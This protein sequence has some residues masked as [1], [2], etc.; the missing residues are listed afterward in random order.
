MKEGFPAN[1]LIPHYRIVNKLGEGGMGEVYLAQDTKLE[2]RVALKVLP[3]EVAAD[4]ERLKRFGQEARAAS[5]LNHPN[6]L[7]IYEIGEFE[8]ANYIST[9]FVD[10]DTLRDLLHS[11]TISLEK[12][13]DIA[14]QAASAL[15]AAHEAGII[16]RDI[17]PENIMIRHDGLVKV[18][19]FGL[20]KL[21]E[22]PGSDIDSEGETR[23]QVKTAPGVIMGTVQYMSPEQTRAKRT[24]ARS[25]IWSLGCV[26]YEMAAGRPPF[27]GETT[28]DLI[29]EIVKID[30][31]PLVRVVPEAPERLDE[32]VSKALEKS[33]D[34]RYQTV[35]DLLIDLRRLKKKL[36]AE[37]DLDRSHSPHITT[38]GDA[39]SEGRRTEILQASTHITAE[40]NSTSSGAQYLTSGIKQHKFGSAA[41]AVLILLVLGGF[42]YG[43]Y[44]F[45]EKPAPATPVKTVDSIKVQRLTGDGRSRDPRISPDGKFLAYHKLE[46]AERSLWIKQI[47][48][49]SNIPVIKPGELDQFGPPTFSPDGNF[50]Y[51]NAASKSE[52]APAVY[53]VPTLGGTPTKVLTN[54]MSVRFSP[55]GR[56]ISF[57]RFDPATNETAIY[58]ANS[59]GTNERKRRQ[60]Q[61]NNFSGRWR[62]GHPTGNRWQPQPAMIRKTPNRWP[63]SS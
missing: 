33:P 1:S 44:K 49:N 15:A 8:A 24:D 55:D 58:V 61:A 34:E 40:A 25:D 4:G 13:L 53:R 57:G 20:A 35:K 56:E 29:A 36:D 18:L 14:I 50:V 31:E 23:A 45:L 6:I 19:D 32:I 21:S 22:S 46:G 54:A 43:I 11:K 3:D 16:H 5:A 26:I 48:T 9:E 51:F 30:P 2:R 12:T 28:A 7:T 52:E 60:E 59:D 63:P 37:S 47:Q 17:K 42:G 10:G 41:V 27:T 38:S 39:G 62:H